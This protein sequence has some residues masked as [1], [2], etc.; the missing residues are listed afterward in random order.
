MNRTN[1]EMDFKVEL[2]SGYANDHHVAFCGA[3]VVGSGDTVG[4]VRPVEE[5]T[6]ITPV[7]SSKTYNE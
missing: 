3:A 4:C 6:K 7:G 2:L 1:V 5:S